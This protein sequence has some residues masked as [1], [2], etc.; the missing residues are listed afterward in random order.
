MTGKCLHRTMMEV[1]AQSCAHSTAEAEAE[2]D[3]MHPAVAH[4]F[5]TATSKSMMTPMAVTAGA[6]PADAGTSWSR[7]RDTSPTPTAAT[8][9]ATSADPSAGGSFGDHAG[10]TVPMRTPTVLETTS[11]PQSLTQITRS[12]IAERQIIAQSR[13]V[14]RRIIAQIMR[15]QA[16]RGTRTC[17]DDPPLV[18]TT[19][20]N[21]MIGT[22]TDTDGPLLDA[23]TTMTTSTATTAAA[24]TRTVPDS[25]HPPVVTIKTT[26]MVGAKHYH[27][28]NA[29]N[30]RT[31]RPQANFAHMHVAV[32]QL[33]AVV[34]LNSERLAHPGLLRPDSR[35]HTSQT[36]TS[37]ESADGSI[38]LARRRMSP[39]APSS[40]S[41]PAVATRVATELSHTAPD[42][43]LPV[44]AYG[45][46][47]FDGP[48]CCNSRCNG[49]IA[50]A[51][52]GGRG[53]RS[54]RF[55]GVLH[56]FPAWRKVDPS[57]ALFPRGT[58][59]SLLRDA[60][61]RPHTVTRRE[62]C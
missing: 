34:Q 1:N 42:A 14:A 38:V 62:R 56:P 40:S 11:V 9:C 43:P 18:D 27:R 41:R 19:R 23:T 60:A 55:L 5:A 58:L 17:P 16:T 26:A 33:V 15:R 37:A 30:M 25:P 35:P 4:L 57:H 49:I 6:T 8:V 48:S 29:H 39:M 51:A 20:T 47:F 36:H 52:S 21:V 3:V 44:I 61:L 54:E 59:A 50:A 10:R 32:R 22:R 45:S 46:I 2:T 13:S 7:L 53:S 24:G 12:P 28:V 31:L